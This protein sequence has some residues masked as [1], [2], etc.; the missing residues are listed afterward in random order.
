MTP[1]FIMG[2]LK[3]NKRREYNFTVI[4]VELSQLGREA[5]RCLDRGGIWDRTQRGECEILTRQH[6]ERRLCGVSLSEIELGYLKALGKLPQYSDLKGKTVMWMMT[7][8]PRKTG[9]RNV[10]LQEVET[11]PNTGE[12]SHARSN[13]FRVR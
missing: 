13:G 1:E 3:F 6:W 8:T 10:W 11:D 12:Q 9:N 2:F 5:V 4:N 7:A